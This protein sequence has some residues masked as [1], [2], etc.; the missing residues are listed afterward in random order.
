MLCNY[1]SSGMFNYTIYD[2]LSDFLRF[3]FYF[4]I[5]YDVDNRD[6]KKAPGGAQKTIRNVS[7]NIFYPRDEI[8]GIMKQELVFLPPCN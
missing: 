4:H 2:K 8:S 1:T 7:V 6:I 5:R 3:E